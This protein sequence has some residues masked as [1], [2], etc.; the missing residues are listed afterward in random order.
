MERWLPIPEYAAYEVSD[1]GHV[2]ALDRITDRGRNWRARQNE[3]V[4]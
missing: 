2:R 3:K 1:L 4:A